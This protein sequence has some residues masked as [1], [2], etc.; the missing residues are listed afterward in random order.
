M[1]FLFFFILSILSFAQTN[2]TINLNEVKVMDYSQYNQFRPKFKKVTRLTDHTSFGLKIFSTLHLPKIDKE[3]EILA[4]EILF[5]SEIK[6]KNYCNEYYYFKPIII[7][8]AQNRTNLIDEK[9]FEVDKDY[10]GRYI[11]PVRL[12]LNPTE[13]KKWLIG[14]ET[15]YDNPFCPEANGYFDLIEVKDKSNFYYGID[16]ELLKQD[17]LRNYVINYRIY[18]K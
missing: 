10:V 18:Y 5:E 13:A 14:F 2:D 8:S 15:A 9:W 6:N 7:K 4:I 11:F 12:K 1:R 3:I 17:A 16:G